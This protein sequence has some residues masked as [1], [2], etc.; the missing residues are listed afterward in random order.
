MRSLPR[1]EW[2]RGPDREI[3]SRVFTYRARRSFLSNVRSERYLLQSL[4]HIFRFELSQRTKIRSAP[5][6][7][8][9]PMADARSFGSNRD[10]T[11][12]RLG[13]RTGHQIKF[14]R[15]GHLD[16]L[17]GL[18]VAIRK[19]STGAPREKLGESAIFHEAFGEDGIAREIE[20]M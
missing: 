15:G 12:T 3:E 2:N 10:L 7:I 13:N 4:E 6:E 5:S 11:W 18:V 17:V 16:S 8:S 1:P 20:H 19:S 9:T 14:P